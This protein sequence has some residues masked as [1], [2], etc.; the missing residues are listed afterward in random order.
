MKGEPVN[1]P[2]KYEIDETL[3]QKIRLNP[4]INR[5]KLIKDFGLSR[6]TVSRS[7]VRLVDRGIV[8][9]RGAPKTGGYYV[10]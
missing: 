6:S 1:E 8:E 10:C 5:V 2:V 3:L 9:F 7:L 4:G